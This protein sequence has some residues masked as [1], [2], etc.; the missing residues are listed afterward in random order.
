VIQDPLAIAAVLFGVI[1][2][3]L[4]LVERY[5]WAEKVSAVTLILLFGAVVSNL[6]LIP[7]DAPLYGG[8]VDL[9]IPFA[10]CLILLTVDLRDVRDAGVPMIA[11]FGIATVGTVMGVVIAGVALE[12]L[13]GGILGEDSWR[14]AGPYTG[15]FIGGSVNF[16]ALWTGLE[17]GRPDLL[18]AANAVDNLSLIPLI[19]IWLTVPV[20]LAGKFPVAP[21]WRH[22]EVADEA[23]EE[24]T[25]PSLNVTHV[26]VLL[27]VSLVIVAGSGA[28]KAAVIDRFLPD[29]PSILLVTTFALAL[30]QLKFMRRF[31]GAW[32]LGHI[33]FYVFFA[34]VGAMINIYNAIVLSP[35]LFVYVIIIIAVHMTVIY[36]SGRLLKMD[37]GVLT[38]ASCAAKAGPAL[39]LGL[40]QTH[41]EWKHIALPGVLMAL[42]GYAIGNY[43]GYAVAQLMRLLV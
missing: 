41:K 22:P 42:V 2:L 6:G 43:I 35:I 27:F 1:L 32:E 31:Q 33:A 11:A 8:M 3:A 16:F 12:P 26:V 14:I 15:T 20:F 7:T 13:L 40:A 38:I 9:A 10:V 24:E 18:A 21:R 5:R 19:T 23:T 25:T 29:L 4:V 39:V 36:G 28:I 17:I 30:G 37:V 34:A